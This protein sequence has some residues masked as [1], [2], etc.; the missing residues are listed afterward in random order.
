MPSTKAARRHSSYASSDEECLRP[1]RKRIHAAKIDADIL[2][3]LYDLIEQHQPCEQRDTHDH[4]IADIII[5]GIRMRRR[6]ER[7]VDWNVAKQKAIVTPDWLRDSV[8]ADKPLPCGGYAAISELHDETVENCPDRAPRGADSSQSREPQKEG[9]TY[10]SP[11]S[12]QASDAIQ[13][14]NQRPEDH[15]SSKVKRNW[16]ASYACQR[17]SPLI[18]PN[19][20]LVTELD[21]LYRSR[22]LEGKHI[23]ALSYERA[24][25]VSYPN[26]L[27]KENFKRDVENLPHIGEKIRSKIKDFLEKGYIEESETIR[28]S[29]R[30]QSL[31]LFSSIYGVGPSTARRLYDIGLRTIEDMERYYDIPPGTDSSALEDLEAELVT[32]NGREVL[33]QD[34]LPAMSIKVAIAL[35]KE[36]DIKIPREEAER[37]HAIVMCE[38]EKFQPGCISTVVGGYRRGKT[39]SNDVDIV[40]SHSDLKR[41]CTRVTKHLHELGLI[42]H[43]MHL[44]GFHAHDGLRTEHWDS[45][46]KALTVFVLPSEK[47]CRKLHRRVDLIFAAPE[48]YWT[49]VVGWTGSKMFERDLRL[50][51]KRE[52]G[53]KF[54]SSGLTRQVF[55]ILDL[56]WIDPPLRNADI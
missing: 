48:A 25:A 31:T 1:P 53:M 47:G 30:F 26:V 13:A 19:Q 36:L 42:T 18:C 28:S 41:L 6:L 10:P 39:E 20:T 52:R 3:E 34:K 16:S 5:T 17:A 22:E 54:D 44:S 27:T 23:N 11:P 56:E 4:S 29:Q 7:H 37:I 32:P 49:A 15:T 40:I 33:T 45:L 8:K 55:D 38:L 9:T 46:E 35:R 50:W 21:I 51:A 14:R 12:S 43:V 24:I 2:K